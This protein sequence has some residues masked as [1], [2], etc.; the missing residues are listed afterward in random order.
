MPNQKKPKGLVAAME[1]ITL[2][3]INDGTEIVVQQPIEMDKD[4][5][6]VMQLDNAANSGET[7]LL[8]MTEAEGTMVA[9][10]NMIDRAEGTID[11]LEAIHDHLAIAAENGGVD[12]YSAAA[13]S[14][15][16]EALYEQAGIYKN[17]LPAME[18]YGGVT[19]KIGATQLAMEDIRANVGKIWD[20]IIAALK[21]AWAWI[22]NFFQ[23]VGTAATAQLERAKQFA[24]SKINGQPKAEPIDNKEM[25][26]AIS[27]NGSVS[28]DNILK[29]IDTLNRRAESIFTRS[30]Q[31]MTQ[32]GERIIQAVEKSIAQHDNT[33]LDF[34][35]PAGAEHIPETEV[36]P[37]NMHFTFVA[38]A[39]EVSGEEAVAA[40]DAMKDNGVHPAANAP[41]QQDTK[42]S[43]LSADGIRKAA[44]MVQQ[45]LEKVL[46]YLGTMEVKNRLKQAGV[47][48]MEKI[49]RAQE[50][51]STEASKGFE[52]VKRLAKSLVSTVDKAVTSFCAYV[53]RVCKRLL[54]FVA[55]SLNK[56]EKPAMGAE[57]PAPETTPA[58][59]TEAP[60]APAAAA[61]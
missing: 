22:K 5:T 20:A 26:D 35:L 17:N 56:Y 3:S 9:H 19:S 45:I 2:E 28:P 31:Y 47:S 14:V 10:E 38:P 43:I 30:D 16:V 49:K 42:L 59:Q 61:A 15:A 18:N 23:N 46:K 33:S 40:L 29:G 52:V 48:A 21:Q 53:V 36:L 11:A 25:A 54:D 32:N 50:T 39:Q 60:A 44:A 13:I 58:A 55:E 34:T 7:K 51:A 4:H 24:Q 12:R 1:S 27:I 41:T 6:H 8:D 57:A 37:G